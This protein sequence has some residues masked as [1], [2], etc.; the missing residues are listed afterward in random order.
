[1]FPFHGRRY[2]LLIYRLD[3]SSSTSTTSKSTSS[4]N[5]QASNARDTPPA[6]STQTQTRNDST[7]AESPTVGRSGGQEIDVSSK[8]T[9]HSDVRARD[10]DDG[11]AIEGKKQSP[12]APATTIM[13]QS[14][15]PSK[16]GYAPN[17]EPVGIIPHEGPKGETLASASTSTSTEQHDGIKEIKGKDNRRRSHG[18][19]HGSKDK[20]GTH[21]VEG[22]GTDEKSK[23]GFG[24]RLSGF[25][26]EFLSPIFIL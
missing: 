8:P 13:E 3:A 4:R 10:A 5:P 7:T 1:M 26:R 2:H 24:K 16:K 17:T 12:S 11:T 22:Q 25:F 23:G 21:E 18:S 19:R 20:E 14:R 15:E 6:S 9:E